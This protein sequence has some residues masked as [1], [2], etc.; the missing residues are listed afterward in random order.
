MGQ[1][2]DYLSRQ[3]AAADPKDRKSSVRFATTVALPTYTFNG[4]ANSIT[5]APAA[6][7]PVQD[8]VTPAQGDSF[9]LTSDGSSSDVHNGIWVITQL[10]PF[11]CHRR[12][13]ANAD[14][15]V[16]G[17]MRV[18]VEEGSVYPSGTEFVL[19]TPNPIVLNTTALTFEVVDADDGGFTQI[20]VGRTKVVYA[21]EQVVHY[22]PMFING[23]LRVSGS[24]VS[25]PSVELP[26]EAVTVSSG[27]ALVAN[28]SLVP[29]DPSGGAFTVLLPQSGTP[30]HEVVLKNVTASVNPITV[31]GQG[32][33]IDGVLT[34]LLV[35]SGASM[36]LRR[37]KNQTWTVV[38]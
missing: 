32:I 33:P 16:D 11:I 14:D 36:V 10:S 28:N 12:S 26:T 23:T 22:G 9:L 19:T 13:D 8:G 3:L 27:P 35:G 25:L 15:L 31:D 38:D 6:A 5:A 7:F 4:P 37:R 1:D 18:A 34:K 17:G 24:L 2:K 21:G 20:A 29:L 30:G